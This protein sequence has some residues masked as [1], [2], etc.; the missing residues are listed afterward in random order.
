VSPPL[1][2]FSLC[3][4]FPR[5]GTQLPSQAVVDLPVH[6]LPR[7]VGMMAM[8]VAEMEKQEVKVVAHSPIEKVAVNKG[9][10]AQGARN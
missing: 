5:A 8:Q 2:L 7:S 3:V 6:V 4:P 1:S 10:A 9:F